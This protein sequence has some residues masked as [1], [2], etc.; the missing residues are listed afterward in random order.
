MED[1]L[2]CNACQA[3]VREVLMKVY[4]NNKESDVIKN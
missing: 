2:W 4:Y 3:I 1:A